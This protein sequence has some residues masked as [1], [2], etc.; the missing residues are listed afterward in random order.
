MIRIQS[1]NPPIVWQINTSHRLPSISGQVRW[2][3][4]SREFE[5][6][7]PNGSWH[8]IDPTVELDS[9]PNIAQVIEWARKK[10]EFEK[11][12]EKLAK[13]YPAV[14]DAKEKLEI[15]MKLVE[16]NQL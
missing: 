5:V 7:D 1:S 4:N 11:K 10:M 9:P 16:D 13:E 8:R 6:A 14:K 15:V 3:G 12:L 2:N